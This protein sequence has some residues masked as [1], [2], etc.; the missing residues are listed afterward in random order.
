MV[1]HHISLYIIIY[2]IIQCISVE[3]E[4]ECRGM[5]WYIQAQ[6]SYLRVTNHSTI[7]KLN[8]IYLSTSIL[9]D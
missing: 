7:D 3:V 1:Y 6:Y 4:E 2:I 8:D 9:I 5:A